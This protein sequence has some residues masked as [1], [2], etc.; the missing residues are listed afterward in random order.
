MLARSKRSEVD[1]MPWCDMC[2]ETVKERVKLF[3]DQETN[4]IIQVCMSCLR[5]RNIA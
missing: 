5:R 4:E 1:E 3:K 2:E